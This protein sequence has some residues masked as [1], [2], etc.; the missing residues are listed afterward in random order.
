MVETCT[1]T[2]FDIRRP[3]WNYKPGSLAS[4]SDSRGHQDGKRIPKEPAYGNILR[5]TMDYRG[6]GSGIIRALKADANIEFHN[7]ASGDQFR[8]ILWRVIK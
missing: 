7:E 3:R 5:K 6:L 2:D 4:N 1:D 8:V